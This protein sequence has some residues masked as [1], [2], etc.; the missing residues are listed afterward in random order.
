MTRSRFAIVAD[1]EGITRDR[2]Y[3]EGRWGERGFQVVDTGGFEPDSTDE[4]LQQMREQA[5]LAMAQAAIVFFVVD[6]RAG[7]TPADR[8]IARLLREE[9]GRASCRAGVWGWRAH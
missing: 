1:E 3:G 5:Q 9:I 6:A 4:L 7:L 8:E 2:Q